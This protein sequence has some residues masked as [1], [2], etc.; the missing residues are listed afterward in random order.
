MISKNNITISKVAVLCILTFVFI[1]IMSSVL[2]LLVIVYPIIGWWYFAGFL[3]F[4]LVIFLFISYIILCSGRNL[5]IISFILFSITLF[6]YVFLFIIQKSS[7]LLYTITKIIF[8]SITLIGIFLERLKLIKNTFIFTLIS[9]SAS[10]ALLAISYT[11]LFFG[12]KVVLFLLYN[13]SYESLKNSYSN[14]GYRKKNAYFFLKSHICIYFLIGSMLFST[15][16]IFAIP[17]YVEI[18]ANNSPELIFWASTGEL[19]RDEDTLVLCR[20]HDIGFAV[21]LRE[22]YI[23]D[24]GVSEANRIEYLLNHSII[25][26]IV[27]GGGTDDFYLSTDNG[28]EFFGI[29]KTIRSWLIINDLYYRYDNMRGFLVDAEIPKTYYTDLENKDIYQ[30]G[31]YFVNQLPSENRLQKIQNALSD[32]IKEIHNDDKKMGIIKLPTVFDNLDDDDDYNKLSNT[33]YALDL[34]WDFSVSMNYRTMHIPTVWDYMIRDTGKYDYTTDYEPAYL[35][36]TQLERNIV[37]IS[38]FFQEVSYEIYNNEISGVSQKHRYIFIGT[39]NKKFKETSYIQNDEWKKDLDVCRHFGV[40]KV[41]F[42]DY[43]KFKRFY[44]LDSL[45][46][47]NESR[48]KWLLIIPNYMITRELFVSLSVIILDKMFSI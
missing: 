8:I 32:T 45:I 17:N 21:V 7:I 22:N 14:I 19:P 34:N 2:Q 43:S 24:G 30:K 18:N 29:F 10:I 44:S 33:I 20:D 1:A 3:I 26:Y 46:R 39:F 38:T 48:Q 35:S 23:D 41:F 28:E 36:K 4:S 37:P 31:Q 47:H 27:L 6:C 5:F 16:T 13:F 15:I 11:E 9:L 12:T 40:D 42:Y 25:V